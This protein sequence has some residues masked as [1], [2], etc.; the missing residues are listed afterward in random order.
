VGNTLIEVKDQASLGLRPYRWASQEDVLKENRAKFTAASK[1]FDD[2]R[3]FCS[4]KGGFRRVRLK[5]AVER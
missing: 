1:V 2:F 4:A 3:V 5:T